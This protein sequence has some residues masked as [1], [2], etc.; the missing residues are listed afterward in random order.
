MFASKHNY[1]VPAERVLSSI[2]ICISASLYDNEPE[3]TQTNPLSDER[4][5]CHATRGRKCSSNKIVTNL[6]SLAMQTFQLKC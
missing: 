4:V 1:E 2:F 5:K 6:E 3:F